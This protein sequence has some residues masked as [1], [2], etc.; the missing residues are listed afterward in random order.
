MSK[1]ISDCP[2]WMLDWDKEKNAYNGLSPE[3]ITIGSRQRVFWSCHICGGQWD[4]VVKE[5][6]GCPYCSGFK[7]LP[8]FNDLATT[9]P[10]LCLEW[11]YEKNEIR[12]SEVT[13]GSQKK[14][15][16]KCEKG[17]SW[18]MLVRSRV[19]GQGCPYCNN[20]RVLIGYNDLATVRPDLAAEW[21]FE[22]M[23][24]FLH[25]MLLR[26]PKSMSGGDVRK[27]TNGRL[28][29]FIEAKVPAVR[30][31]QTK[32]LSKNIMILQVNI[33][34]CLLNGTITGTI[35]LR[36][37]IQ[38]VPRNRYGGYARRAIPGKRQLLID[39]REPVVRNVLKNDR[40]HFRKRLS[41][42]IFERL[43]LI[44]RQTIELTGHHR[45]KWIC[46]LRIRRLLL[47][48]MEFMGIPNQMGLPGMSGKTKC[49][50]TIMLL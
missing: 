40:Y 41:S 8:G 4:T 16:W 43:F 20:R 27:V 15:W 26:D 38:A 3:R 46:I 1:Y 35:N 32:L 22:K 9:N 21:N 42:T 29:S 39:A 50:L 49:A 34:N 48:M 30:Y 13:A 18:D 25:L 6:R 17:H 19:L 10:E 45:M 2:D 36:K 28:K 5:R 12:P 23:G 24:F 31:V 44:Y 33:R 7:A 14:V 11:D 47:N 37:N